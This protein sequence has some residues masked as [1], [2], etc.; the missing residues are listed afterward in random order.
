[1]PKW[2]R[3]PPASGWYFLVVDRAIGPI[4]A[5]VGLDLLDPS[6]K[7]HPLA[8]MVQVG[9]IGADPEYF[10]FWWLYDKH[11][12]TDLFPVHGCHGWWYG[13]IAPESPWPTR[14]MDEPPKR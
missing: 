5:R 6:I 13:P 14:F 7:G 8:H 9:D 3:V 4:Q 12:R 11:P 2:T 10:R 1:M